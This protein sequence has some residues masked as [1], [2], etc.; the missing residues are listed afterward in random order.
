MDA[1]KLRSYSSS[2]ANSREPTPCM[3]DRFGKRSAPLSI[4]RATSSAWLGGKLNRNALFT[5]LV[6]HDD[7]LLS[8]DCNNQTWIKSAAG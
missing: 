1:N 5:T 2:K 8:C 6:R 3:H 7:P 4:W